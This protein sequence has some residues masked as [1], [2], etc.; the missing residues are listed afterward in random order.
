MTGSGCNVS[1]CRMC[2][3]VWLGESVSAEMCC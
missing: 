2:V 3:T 1:E